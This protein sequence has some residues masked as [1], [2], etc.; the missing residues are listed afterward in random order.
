MSFKWPRNSGLTGKYYYLPENLSEQFCLPTLLLSGHMVNSE[1]DLTTRLFCHP[2]TGRK[3]TLTT[4]VTLSES[5]IGT[6]L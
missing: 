2:T 1:V 4:P 3:S 5:S 6:E